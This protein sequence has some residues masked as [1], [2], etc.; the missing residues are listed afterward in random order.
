LPEVVVHI[1]HR[2]ATP[3]ELSVQKENNAKKAD[4]PLKSDAI[5]GGSRLTTASL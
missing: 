1:F 5:L 4:L 3:A 2:P